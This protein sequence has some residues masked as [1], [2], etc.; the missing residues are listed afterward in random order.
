[1][2]GSDGLGIRRG[3]RG[4]GVRDEGVRKSKAQFHNPINPSLS[5]EWINQDPV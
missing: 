4:R 1:M 2:A 3:G 5:S